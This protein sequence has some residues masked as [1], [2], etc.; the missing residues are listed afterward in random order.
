MDLIDL[1]AEST[2]ADA[3]T[4]VLDDLTGEATVPP[5]DYEPAHTTPPVSGPAAVNLTDPVA[6]D[7]RQAGPLPVLLGAPVDA[8]P[9]EASALDGTWQV[10][11]ADPAQTS[12]AEVNGT[13]LTVTPPAT[14]ATASVEVALD[15]SDFEQL[16][17]ADWADRMQFVTYPECFLTTPLD[18]ACN[19]ATP[20]ATDNDDNTGQIKATVDVAA[21]SA[22]ADQASLS[23]DNSSTSESAVY[24][25]DASKSGALKALL[26]QAGTS[27][28]GSVVLAATDSGSGAKGD[29]TATPLAASGTW[30][31]GGSAGAFT[32]SQ[33]V[34]VPPVPAGPAPDIAFGYNSQVVD[35]RTSATNNQ[36]SWIGDGWDYQ[37]GSI[38]RTYRT[39]RDDT[40]GDANNASHKTS[41]LCW[42]S[43]NAV[44]SLGGSTTELVV[45]AS[46]CPDGNLDAPSCD[47]VTA[48]GDGSRVERIKDTSKDNGDKDGEYWRV[49]TRDGTQYYFGLNKLPGWSSSDETT[50][51]VLTVPVAG[52]QSGEPCHDS[53]F[54]SSFCAQ[55]WRWNLDYVVDV[56]G[57][58][59][60]LWWDKESNYYGE[61]EKYTT[62]VSYDR[63]GYL[64]RIDYGQRSNTLFTADP[65]A[66]VEFTVDE[67]CFDEAETGLTC[68]NDAFTSQDY[69]QY[70]LWYDTPANLYCSGA[71]GKRCSVGAPT[72]WSRERLSSVTTYAQRTQSSTTL[73]KVDKYLLTQ[74][75]PRTLTDTAPP[76]WLESIQRTGYAVDGTAQKLNAVE[77][78]HNNQ[79][80]PNRVITGASDPRPAFDR[81]RIR[82]VVTE[83]GGEIDVDYSD[84][85]PAMATSAHPKPEENGTRCYPVYWSPDP[86]QET[87]DWFNKY[88]VTSITQKP[89]VDGV[90]DLVTEYQYPT[91]G[92]AWAKNQTEFSKKTTRT[93]DQWR[94]YEQVTVL[95]GKN[96]AATGIVRG[97]SVTRY[98]RGMDGDPLPGGGTRSVTV[99]DSTGATIAP[100]KPAF[101]GMTAESLTYT[102]ANDDGTGGSV[103]SR[104]V[105]S[106]SA[107]LLA[108]RPRTDVPDLKAYRTQV[109]QSIKV[110]PA[111]GTNPDDNRTSRTVKT[112]TLYDDTYGLPY[113]VETRADTGK[114]GD[115]TT[116]CTQTSY[117]HNT[118][119]WLIGLT[120]QTKTTAGT[121]AQAA[122]ATGDDVISASR[123]AYDSQSYGTAP[124]KGEATSVWG[125]DGLGTGWIRASKT[126]Y[127]DYGRVKTV[128]D[129][130][131]H[132]GTTDYNPSS[133]QVFST[134]ATNNTLGFTSTI[135]VEPGR[136]S[137]VKSEDTNKHVVTQAYDAL[138]RTTAVWTASQNPATDDPSKTFSYD[139]TVG[140]PVAV[141]TST[142]R[143]DGT[144]AHAVTLYDGLG[145]PRQSQTDAVGGGRIVTDTLYNAAG[146]V[147]RTNNGYYAAGAP[148]TTLFE[149]ESD[150][151]VPSAT[152]TTYDGQSRPVTVTPYEAGTPKT[153]KRTTYA[154]DKDVTTV[155]PPVG[156]PATRSFTDVLQRTVRIDEFTDALHAAHTSTTYGYDPRGDRVSAT[157]T[158]GNS[159]SWTYD[160][161]G[162]QIR[163]VDP[164]TGTTT[165]TYDDLDHKLTTTDDRGITVWTGYDA[166][167]R[168][169][170]Q[171]LD[172]DQGEILTKFTYDT[173]P[174]AKGQQVSATRYNDGVPITTTVTGYDA[175]Y[176]PTGKNITIPFSLTTT[177]T[178]GLD[179]TYSYS[180][181]YTKTGLQQSVTTPAVGGLSQE[182]VITRYNADGLPTS[183]SG[184]D[185]YTAETTYSPYGEVLRT[186]TGEMPNR[187]WTTNLFDEN[188]GQLDRTVTDRETA[189]PNRVNDR[190]YTYDNAGN[191]TQLKDTDGAGSTDRQ[192]FTYDALGQLHEAWTSPN[193]GCTASGQTI[194]APVYTDTTGKVTATNVTSA[195]DGYWQTYTYD[196]LGN[197]K[198]LTEH[199]PSV[200]V[201]GGQVDATD[202]TTTD[203]AY[204]N[205]TGGQPHTL[206]GI[207]TDTATID[208]AAALSYD[209]TGNTET[210]TYG[211]D[212]QALDWTWDG[213]VKTV[214]GFGKAGSGQLIGLD[215]KCLDLQS[216]STADK[217]PL[218]IYTCNGTKAQ[219]FRLDTQTGALTVLGKCVM[220][221]GGATTDSTPVTLAPC[222]G[223]A[224]QKWTVTAGTLKYSGSSK[225]LDIPG[226]NS[227]D[228]TDLQITACNG[229]T[230]QQWAFS[231]QTS[232]LYDASGN[233][234]IAATASAHTLY[235]PD[236]ELSTDAN[237]DVAYCQR[238]YSQAG[239]PT[240]MRHTEGGTSSTLTAL[241]ADQQGTAIAAIG[242]T[243]GQAIQRQKTDPF[244][245][246]RGTVDGRWQSHRS[247][248]GGTD[249]TTTGLTHLGAREYDPDTGHFISADPVL[250]IADP[251]QMNGYAYA[252]N[253]PVTK[254]DP[255][256]LFVPGDIAGGPISGNSGSGNMCPSLQNPNCP[257]YAGGG[258]GGGGGDDNTSGSGH[259]GGGGLS[260]WLGDVGKTIYHEV[261]TTGIALV[262]TPIQQLQTDK[263][264]IT[265]GDDCMAMLT[266][267]VYSVSPAQAAAAA[268]TSRGAE[269][270]DDYAHG[271]SAQGTGKLIFDLAMLVGTRGAGAEVE[272]E[273]AATRIRIPRGCSF[274][275]STPVLMADGK[276]KPIG[277]IKTGDKVEAADPANG[278]RKGGRKVAATLINHDYDL[279]DLRIK[280]T[281]GSTEILHTN[282]KHPFWDDTLHTWVPAGQLRTGH[283]LSTAIGYHVYVA[284][285]TRLPGDRDMYNLTVDD[286]HTYYV[287]AGGT[288]ILVHNTGEACRVFSVDSSGTA[289]SLPVHEID[290]SAYPGVADNFNNALANGESP[291]VTRL[292]GR[293]AIRANRNAAQAGQPRPG[294]LMGGMSWEE[295]PFASTVEGGSGATLRLIPRN[296]NVSHGRD[297][298]W[299]FLRDNGINSGDQY[300]VRT[301]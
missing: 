100:D 292:T 262:T 138:G 6:G 299:P 187:V 109:D 26:P 216:A 214:S 110:T 220:P 218:Q 229:N 139:I 283:A 35:G 301:Q 212:T 43:Y 118:S 200:T 249:D 241:A 232:Y 2:A 20:L 146:T 171:R 242:L 256:G 297:S 124:T 268:A 48:N 27:G 90:P 102:Q 196:T 13:L 82:R 134:T 198:R 71:A 259:G 10:E 76:L 289:T 175:E 52:N 211:G 276:T 114:T 246:P 75:F 97:K 223:K 143:D 65:I 165:T 186:V 130:A 136:G 36:A 101:Q 57:N 269:I 113:Q 105:S 86:D 137:P 254:S 92:A 40:D 91:D 61:N 3:D 270:A 240:V 115:Q 70:R 291:I 55:G 117:L 275:P 230:A 56:H 60:S 280:R 228:G 39:C 42:G 164:D 59:M 80:M 176:R 22:T 5:V 189:A 267:L 245:V 287:V 126:T 140:K 286:L 172:D 8:T 263:R 191:V 16:Y 169:T 95:T 182:K 120:E 239:A 7:L 85:C 121:C 145:R 152:V 279:V 208:T 219:N 104:T 177:A 237:G 197:R 9:E 261:K 295:F 155:V 184:L 15:Y 129:A 224:D 32:W 195:N 14:A 119:A 108:T 18:E 257:E 24:H 88:V 201:T 247:Y 17:S 106:P 135:T 167:G 150:F 98:F 49:T 19:Q 125:Q 205:D 66:R 202:D 253:N 264:C 190:Y 142:L 163:A 166:L 156:S 226:A 235:L 64:K 132:I 44:L 30:S 183:T 25:R 255:T 161:R 116:T 79:A 231:D 277:D 204:G 107:H 188:T 51:S 131:G 293:A 174:G 58:A 238:Y 99:K 250:D 133:G 103:A 158:E 67:R 33:P 162:R 298:L 63:G 203:Y 29:Y 154:Y 181:T 34:A 94:G 153:V 160:A 294:T 69:G 11:V 209:K 300:Y 217:T 144:Y 272:G 111:S 93:Y 23:G 288:P 12:A 282:A 285:I 207:T 210:R 273:V 54:A 233:R 157:D 252:N 81:L 296:E 274:T 123:T 284:D 251:L 45:D 193:E 227:A 179:A 147:R 234:I 244:G 266:Q 258:G 149:L 73:S 1:P 31:A 199:D 96:D 141:S 215:G 168:T 46:T 173:I 159:W 170:E 47:W 206:T 62:P 265:S 84:P 178:T 77:F 281:D 78:S 180:Y 290:S 213:K 68:T 192:C 21:A 151:D 221:T 185:W 260:G 225:C 222:T 53:D 122:T 50:D 38:E 278:K 89:R 148:S 112:T 83:Y 243:T 41:D 128:E 28:S 248:L 236:T 74:T 87:I 127:D 4:G 37:P 72:F 194:A 271:R